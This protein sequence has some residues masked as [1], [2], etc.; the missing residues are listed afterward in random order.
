MKYLII[1]LLMGSFVYSDNY[2][3]EHG[4]MYPY[5]YFKTPEQ[6]LKEINRRLERIKN[7]SILARSNPSNF[8]DILLE[9]HQDILICIK[10]S[11]GY[12]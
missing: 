10:L 8:F 7:L 3:F 9:I 6:N 1:F 2:L 12:Q 5:E 4:Q 11:E